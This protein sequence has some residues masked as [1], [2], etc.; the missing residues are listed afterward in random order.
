MP[1]ITFFTHFSLKK[2]VF[3]EGVVL[4]F[5]SFQ[6]KSL[7][8]T[9]KCRAQGSVGKKTTKLKPHNKKLRGYR[10]FNS[11]AAGQRLRSTQGCRLLIVNYSLSFSAH[12]F[13]LFFFIFLFFFVVVIT[14]FFY[15]L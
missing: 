3:T 5:E 15:F 12:T 9:V 11:G 1:K 8:Q 7:E 14:A 4:S 10:L 2:D 6:Q 13:F